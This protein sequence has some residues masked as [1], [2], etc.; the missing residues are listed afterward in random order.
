MQETKPNIRNDLVHKE[1]AYK[2]MGVVMNVYNTLGYGHLE[3]VYQKALAIALAK[4]GF[5]VVEQLYAPVIFE[6]TVIGKGYLDFLIN[7]VLVLEIKKGDYFAKAHIGQVHEYL[8]SKN[9]ELGLLVYFAPRTV[10]WKR[11]VNLLD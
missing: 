3:K 2:V 4:A 8:V 5:T 10:H 6:D 11:I 1:L 7:D 9:L